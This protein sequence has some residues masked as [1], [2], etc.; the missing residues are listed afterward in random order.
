MVFSLSATSLKKMW[1]QS[2][3]IWG[4]MANYANFDNCP[5]TFEINTDGYQSWKDCGFTIT[6]PKM[7]ATIYWIISLLTKILMHC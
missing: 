3:V 1:F 6:Y 7:K 2:L 5:F 4:W